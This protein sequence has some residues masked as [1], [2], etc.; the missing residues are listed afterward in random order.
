MLLWIHTPPLARFYFVSKLVV[1]TCIANFSL[2][3][4]MSGK[5]A[6]TKESLKVCKVNL[7]NF[8]TSNSYFPGVSLIDKAIQFN[9][10]F[11]LWQIPLN[12]KNARLFIYYLVY[13]YSP[14]NLQKKIYKI[15]KNSKN[16]IHDQKGLKFLWSNIESCNYLDKK[17]KILLFIFISRSSFQVSLYPWRRSYFIIVIGLK[18]VVL[19][20]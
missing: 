1:I 8:K 7:Q 18:N 4:V 16:Q 20:K 6:T 17:F 19:K 11:V 13:H 14:I 3:T 12:V 9:R 2:V 15:Y 10:S 5:Q